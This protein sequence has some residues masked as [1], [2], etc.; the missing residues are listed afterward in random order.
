MLLLRTPMTANALSLLLVLLGFA[1][2]W[3]FSLG[4]Y[5]TGVAAAALSLGAS[6]LDGC[7]GEIARLKYQESAFGCWVETIGDYTYYIAIFV[8]L[9]VGAVRYTA[10]PIFSRIGA[11][12]LAGTFITFALLIWLRRRITNGQPE[13]L[14]ATAKAHFYASKKRWA[15]LVA[16][17]S[18]CATRSTMPYGIMAFALLGILPGILVLAAIGANVYWISLAIRLPW[19]LAPAQPKAAARPVGDA[20]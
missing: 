13:K 3:L 12:A 5:A 18:F 10:D 15:W 7:D 14:Q 19:L 1:S 8:G 20:A 17:L 2:G 6:I 4:S 11:L 16:K 9:T